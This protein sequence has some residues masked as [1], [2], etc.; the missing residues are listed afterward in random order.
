MASATLLAAG[1]IGWGASAALVSLQDG[2]SPK[3]AAGPSP[4][5]QRQAE[6]AFPQPGPTPSE[7]PGKVKV[8]GRVLGPD[9]RPIAGAK[10]VAA[11]G[12]RRFP[13]ALGP[14]ARVRDDRT[15]RRLPVPR[16]PVG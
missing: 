2:P 6:A 9:G 7:T 13:L 5:I 10:I 16:Q 8:G 3:S 1:L 15:G 11:P 14:V 12:P 4:S